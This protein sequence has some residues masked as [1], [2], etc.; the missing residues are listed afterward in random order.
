MSLFTP[1]PSLFILPPTPKGPRLVTW[2]NR[3]QSSP[4]RA[5]KEHSPRVGHGHY[6][7]VIQK[8]EQGEETRHCAQDELHVKES[9]VFGEVT[10]IVEELQRG[11]Q[12]GRATLPSMTAIQ[13]A[14]LGLIQVV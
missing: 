6:E 7:V 1:H 5:H 13:L 4:D 9:E 8:G 14:V 10:L 2:P 3:G 11:E 12:A